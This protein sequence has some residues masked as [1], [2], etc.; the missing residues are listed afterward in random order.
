[1]NNAWTPQPGW[2]T[3]FPRDWTASNGIIPPLQ[4]LAE[5]YDDVETMTETQVTDIV[6]GA[7]GR[8]IGV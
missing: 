4:E 2:D 5:S 3:V 7:T 6:R 8:A 1:M